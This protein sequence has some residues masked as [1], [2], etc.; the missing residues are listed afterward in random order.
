MPEVI[1]P[2]GKV[3]S[4]DRLFKSLLG[5]F[6]PEFMHLFL[7]DLA[8]RL[9]MTGVKF[10]QQE[11]VGDHGKVVD[12]LAEVRL[13]ATGVTVL[14]HIEVQATQ[15][16]GFARRMLT[17]YVRITERHGRAVAPIAIYLFEPKAQ[18]TIKEADTN[19]DGHD[20]ED[21]G[22]DSSCGT[23]GCRQEPEGDIC[24]LEA[25]VDDRLGVETLRFT[26][27]ALHLRRVKWR[28]LAGVHN[29]VA[30]AL[31]GVAGRRLGDSDERVQVAVGFYRGL[32]QSVV[33]LQDRQLLTGFFEVYMHLSGEER[34]RVRQV[35]E[36]FSPKEA[37]VVEQIWTPLH[38]EGFQEGLAKGYM[39]VILRQIRKRFGQLP[40][41]VDTAIR[42]L[43]AEQ[44]LELAGVLFEIATLEE[45]RVW[46][47]AHAEAV[48]EVGG[49]NGADHDPVAPD[50]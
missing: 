6:L 21:S 5:R 48:R 20:G 29:P 28:E 10:L 49:G 15:E 36:S 46:L 12:L 30:L 50:K 11:L 26:F 32:V 14:I 39:E 34:R 13:A 23:R 2:Q 43:P 33:E 44:V 25:W 19:K 45:L 4:H 8:S 40:P 3:L 38:E 37:E 1:Q 31:L 16:A 35:L 27:Y 7:P 47:G 41:D 17:Y 22:G 42:A 9:D 24:Q 18:D